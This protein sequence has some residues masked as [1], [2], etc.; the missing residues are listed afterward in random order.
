MRVK[1]TPVFYVQ[2]TQGNCYGKT[3][4]E[5]VF[6]G[7]QQIRQI[8]SACQD[9]RVSF[10]KIHVDGQFGRVWSKFQHLFVFLVCS[11]TYL[12]RM[13][14]VPMPSLNV[15]QKAHREGNLE[16]DTIQ[17]MEEKMQA[18]IAAGSVPKTGKSKFAHCKRVRF[19]RFLIL[20]CFPTRGPG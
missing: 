6:V 4:R 15:L 9:F 7:P 18:R 10:C 14:I 2:F 13:N 12:R 11:Y 19:S 17:L 1:V 16:P 3:I 8:K 20:G 5:V